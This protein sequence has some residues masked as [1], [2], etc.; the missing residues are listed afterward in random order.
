MI[1]RRERIRGIQHRIIMVVLTIIVIIIGSRVFSNKLIRTNAA[2][3]YSTQKYYTSVEVKAGDTLWQLADQYMTDDYSSKKEFIAEI[4]T[5]NSLESE[6]IYS[7]CYLV[8]PYY[9]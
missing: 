1:K 7:G 8:I 4:V 5:I 9:Q 6:Q 2:D 3:I